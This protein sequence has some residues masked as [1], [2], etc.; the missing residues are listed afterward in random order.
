[1]FTFAIASPDEFL[2]YSRKGRASSC[3]TDVI[4]F[5]VNRPKHGFEQNY[6]NT[7]RGKN[8][9]DAFGYYSA[10][11]GRIWMNSAAL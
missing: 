7:L 5:F 1:M 4:F 11:S 6:G 9:V 2:L 3:F 8:G 10:E